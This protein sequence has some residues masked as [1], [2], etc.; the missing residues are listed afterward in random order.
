M[1]LSY[2]FPGKR[3]RK[4][5]NIIEGDN[6]RKHFTHKTRKPSSEY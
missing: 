1:L 3:E 5:E 4:L 2:G 6:P